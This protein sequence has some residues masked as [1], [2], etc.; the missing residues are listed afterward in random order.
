MPCRLPNPLALAWAI[1]RSVRELVIHPLSTSIIIIILLSSSSSSSAVHFCF[2]TAYHN[3]ASREVC[4]VDFR[5]LADAISTKEIWACSNAFLTT[6]DVDNPAYCPL[7]TVVFNKDTN[8]YETTE[9]SL[10]AEDD[11][12]L[13]A[14]VM[15]NLYRMEQG[16]GVQKC[17][18]QLSVWQGKT[19]ATT[20]RSTL[21]NL[22]KKEATSKFVGKS[23]NHHDSFATF[24]K[25]YY[26]RT[27]GKTTRRVRRSNTKL[28]NVHVLA[29]QSTVQWALD[30]QQQ[31]STHYRELAAAVIRVQ[32]NMNDGGDVKLVPKLLLQAAMTSAGDGY[33]CRDAM[34]A[35]E[36][37]RDSD[38]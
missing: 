12:I 18:A 24:R 15:W 36:T 34:R 33:F 6:V 2:E 11:F 22:W 27:K 17:L 3:M 20:E 1:C 14:L 38:P 32:Y 23:L 37:A 28:S 30:L 9:V 21:K 16:W 4:E 19:A 7:D 29:E 13:Q 10:L 31:G 5:N 8:R 35:L 25:Y 26:H